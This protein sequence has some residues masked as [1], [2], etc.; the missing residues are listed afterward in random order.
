MPTSPTELQ[1]L[2]VTVRDGSYQIFHN[3]TP[4]H[5]RGIIKEL[6]DAGIRNA[7]VSHGCGIGGKL[8]GFPAKADDEELM[9]A[10][11]SV[12]PGMKLS[13]FIPATDFAASLLPALVEYID[14]GRVGLNVDQAESAEKILKKLKKYQKIAS[15]QFT[16]CHRRPPEVLAEASKIVESMGADIIY[17]VDTFGSMMPKQVQEYVSAIRSKT[18]AVVGFHGHNHIGMAIP[19]SLAALDAGASWV[20]ATLMGVGRD[21]GNANLEALVSV[22]QSRG[23][24]SEI[25]L[26]KLCAATLKVVLPI[27]ERPPVS[28]YPDLLLS[29]FMID[30]PFK[31]FLIL[32][33]NG[34]HVPLERFFQ[35]L[36]EKMGQEIQIND[37]HLKATI[38]AFGENYEQ[39]M[40]SFQNNP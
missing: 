37:Q 25:D 13:A 27:F 36:S 24:A 19:N 14:I 6:Y 34:V 16:R 40:A 11:K 1:I 8:Q 22:L 32:L 29:R 4:E 17:V 35:T 20:D 5:V 38:E 28:R 31:D 3:I 39:L 12:A 21:S 30:Y 9:E 15:V 7:E 2:D 26:N 23:S 10:A 18:K 33:A